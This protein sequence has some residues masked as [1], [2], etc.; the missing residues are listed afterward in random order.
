MAST[1]E[2]VSLFEGRKKVAEGTVLNIGDLTA[3]P[4]LERC[5]TGD[6]AEPATP[7]AAGSSLVETWRGGD[8]DDSGI[9]SAVIWSHTGS[10]GW[11]RGLRQMFTHIGKELPGL[12][13][14]MEI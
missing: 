8:R 12:V 10:T 3:A 13:R 7:V 5:G 9:A 6:V 2:P 11:L 1:S 4:V 14:R